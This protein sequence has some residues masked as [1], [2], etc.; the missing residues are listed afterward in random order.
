VQRGLAY[1]PAD[2]YATAEE[3]RAAF[4]ESVLPVAP[5]SG[6][7]VAAWARA[8][9]AESEEPPLPDA[10]TALDRR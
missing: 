3:M 8:L 5:A 4:L 1:Q 9:L 2:R 10:S 6:A 7:A